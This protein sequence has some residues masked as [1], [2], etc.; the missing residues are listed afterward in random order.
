MKDLHDSHA[1][2]AAV[3]DD[4]AVR[5]AISSLVRSVGYRCV[6]FDSAEDFLESGGLSDTDCALLDIRMPGMNGLDLQS[7]LGEMK[8]KIPVIYVTASPD[9]ELRERAFRQ[10]AIAFLVKP[11]GDEDL[12]DAIDHALCGGPQAVQP[13]SGNR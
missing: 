9:T 3:D 4:E 13:A 12:L 8:C 5:S 7:M 11:F 6:G 1:L 2:I 10:G